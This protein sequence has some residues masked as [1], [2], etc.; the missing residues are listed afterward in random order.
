MNK[1]AKVFVVGA[2]LLG[3]SGFG[4]VEALEYAQV[5]RNNVK[6]AVKDSIPLSV[7]IDRMQVILD[8]MDQ[9]VG[10][11]KYAA[12]KA[13]VALE[14]AEAAVGHSRHDCDSLLSDMKKLRM[15]QSS[16]TKTAC[17]AIQVG[18]YKVSAEDVNQALS[19]KLAG[20]KAKSAALTEQEASLERQRSA[21]RT[22]ATRFEDWSQKRQ[23]LSHRV[24]ALRAR[25][26]AQ[27]AG[28][29]AVD[30][31]FDTTDLARAAQLA[32]DIEHKLRI[33]EKQEALHTSPIDS[34]LG[35]ST[36]ESANVSA[37]VDSV[38]NRGEVAA[39]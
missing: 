26:T 9:Q 19:N 10:Q 8:K 11:Q 38:L 15:I 18:A 29:G 13:Q 27:Q 2:G 39:K 6:E 22:L 5:A 3:L 4:I 30:S 20:W 12:A 31:S 36:V 21:Y 28:S 14:D 37:E 1:F 7:E 33:V 34:L 25:N 17:G 24:E 16:G 35:G 23:L 32:D